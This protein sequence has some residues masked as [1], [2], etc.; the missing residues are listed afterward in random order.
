M[1]SHTDV[2]VGSRDNE[3]EVRWS[4][5][6]THTHTYTLHTQSHTFAA[7]Q[8]WDST[9]VCPLTDGW[10][11]LKCPTQWRTD[12]DGVC[13]CACVCVCAHAHLCVCMCVCDCVCEYCTWMCTGVILGCRYGVGPQPS[14]WSTDYDGT[15][16]LWRGVMC[17]PCGMAA[18]Y[19]V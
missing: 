7:P 17:M 15:Y 19:G 12:C 9:Q 5:M 13:A 2:F 11:M 4:L 18:Y 16:G 3:L 8:R 14:E 6:S 1:G 10:D